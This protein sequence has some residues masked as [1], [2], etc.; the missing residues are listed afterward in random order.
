MHLSCLSISSDT[1]KPVL[2]SIILISVS[3]SS[4]STFKTLFLHCGTQGF[5]TKYV[6][7]TCSPFSFKHP[8]PVFGFVIQY[9]I[10]LYEPYWLHKPSFEWQSV[11]YGSE[12]V[13]Y[14]ILVLI[15]VL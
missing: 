7:N 4:K 2:I 8:A 3:Y 6:P 10:S 11:M 15:F 13:P 5:S 9:L 14:S 12:N 1:F